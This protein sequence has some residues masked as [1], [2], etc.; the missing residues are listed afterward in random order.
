M[1]LWCMARTNIDA[2]DEACATVMR[3]YHLSTKREANNFAS[4]T[5][6]AEVLDLDEA[7]LPRG[8]G[9]EG[10]SE[11]LRASRLG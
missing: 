5:V 1:C 4:R 9:W 3:R 10:D 8:S 2:H 7:R 6:A 11:E